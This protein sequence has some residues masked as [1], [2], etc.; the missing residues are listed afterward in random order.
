M[1]TLPRTMYRLNTIPIKIPMV[2]FLEIAKNS[3][4]ICVESQDSNI[5]SNSEKKNKA[6]AITFTDFKLNYKQ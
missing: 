2:F 3:P 4:K 6:G 1:D 5:Q